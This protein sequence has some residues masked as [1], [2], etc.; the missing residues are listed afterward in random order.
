MRN[1]CS[2]RKPSD[3]HSAGAWIVAQSRSVNSRRSPLR[4][5]ADGEF[6]V[7]VQSDDALPGVVAERRIIGAEMD[8][9]AAGKQHRT[10]HGEG[11]DWV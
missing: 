1:R 11:E 7:A 2:P 3:C 4:A 6:P 9:G 5:V 8:V 10:E